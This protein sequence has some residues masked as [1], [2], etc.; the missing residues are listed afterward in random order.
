M[1]LLQ[2]LFIT[3]VYLGGSALW[4]LEAFCYEIDHIQC[5]TKVF[6]SSGIPVVPVVIPVAI[7]RDFAIAYSHEQ[8][9]EI[10][11]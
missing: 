4:D 8:P 5:Q 1:S 11:L 10:Q 2:V 6:F 3:L 7:D 9:R